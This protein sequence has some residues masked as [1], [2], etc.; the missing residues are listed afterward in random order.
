MK[1]AWEPDGSET[2]VHENDGKSAHVLIRKDDK[3]CEDCGK[4]EYDYD[5][6]EFLRPESIPVEQFK[7]D[8]PEGQPVREGLIGRKIGEGSDAVQ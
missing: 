5:S 4:F 2:F 1:P 7:A 8:F 6:V 3:W